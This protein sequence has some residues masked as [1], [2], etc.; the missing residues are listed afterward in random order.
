LHRVKRDRVKSELRK[1]GFDAI[2]QRFIP[3][4]QSLQICARHSLIY[5]HRTI[6]IIAQMIM[7]QA[8][9]PGF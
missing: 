3:I 5:P 7:R 6:I 9:N 8:L 2:A 1:I 4:A